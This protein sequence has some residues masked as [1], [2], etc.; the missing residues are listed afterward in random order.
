MKLKLSLSVADRFSLDGLRDL[1]HFHI[2]SEIKA[3]DVINIY[4]AAVST[5]PVLG[6]YQLVLWLWSWVKTRSVCFQ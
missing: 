4:V 3:E 2:S 6:Q 1:C 5:T